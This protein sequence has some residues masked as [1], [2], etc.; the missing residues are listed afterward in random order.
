MSA[1]GSWMQLQA[2]WGS[3]C[4]GEFVEYEDYGGDVGYYCDE[5]VDAWAECQACDDT[6]CA[7]LR[8]ACNECWEG[9]SA[10]CEDE[11][12]G[13]DR[14]ACLSYEGCNDR[15][16]RDAHYGDEDAQ[17]AACTS[18][19][20]FCARCYSWGCHSEG[21][22][23]VCRMRSPN[24]WESLSRE[25]CE[26]LG[27]VYD[28]DSYWDACSR[29]VASTGDLET[30]AAA[31]FAA[32]GGGGLEVGPNPDK[33]EW[34]SIAPEYP[35]HG[36]WLEAGCYFGALDTTAVE[37]VVSAYD[38]CAQGDC[39]ELENLDA[40][41]CHNEAV[42]TD[43]AG[44][45]WLEWGSDRH[46]SEDA[47]AGN[48][49]C[50]YAY[51]APN[52]EGASAAACAA[53]G[54]GAWIGATLNFEPGRFATED[55]CAEGRCEG[56][57][58]W[59][60]YTREQ[61]LAEGRY[62]CDMQ[63]LQCVADAW[64]YHNQGGGGCF[65]NATLAAAH[66]GSEPCANELLVTEATCAATA[67]HEWASCAGA[68]A[69]ACAGGARADALGCAWRHDSC[70]DET[71]CEV[72]GWCDDYENERETCGDAGW[73]HGD[74]CWASYETT[75]TDD[76]GN[77]LSWWAYESCGDC[78][79]SSGVCVEPRDGWGCDDNRWHR[80]GCRA[81][82]IATAGECEAVDG[83][84]WLSRAS[85]RASCEATTSCYETM[86]GTTMK[87]DADC[88]AC[89]GDVV[90]AFRWHGGTWSEPT[91]QDLAWFANGQEMVPL[92]TVEKEV[93]DHRVED[94][95]AKPVMKAFAKT[96][97]TRSLLEYNSFS[98]S[99]L[100]LL[101]NCGYDA[102]TSP[103]GGFSG[104]VSASTTTFCGLAD[105]VDAGHAVVAVENECSGRR[106]LE[107]GAADDSVDL[108]LST[109]AV[110]TLAAAR[111][112]AVA[113][114][115]HTACANA[116]AIDALVV[117]GAGGAVV[118]Q[119]LGDG[120]GVATSGEVDALQLCLGTR[121]DVTVYGDYFGT[122]DL[123]RVGDDGATLEA[124]GF[125]LAAS[126]RLCASVDRAGTYFPILRVADVD[127][128]GDVDGNC[129]G[130]GD[131]G[132]CGGRG[133]CVG[134]D[135][136]HCFCGFTG[137]FC[138]SGC[139]NA[140]SGYGTCDDATGA[141]ACAEGRAG[142]ECAAV[143]CPRGDVAGESRYCSLRGTC[144]ESRICEC[145]AG[146]EG[147][148]CET[149]VVSETA[150]GGSGVDA[151]FLES[152]RIDGDPFAYLGVEP[153]P[154]T[155]PSRAPVAREVRI[156]SAVAFSEDL[157]PEA[158][159]GDAE[160]V[161]SFKVILV[162]VGIADAVDRVSDV[163][164]R[165]ARRRRLE[166]AAATVVDFALTV[167]VEVAA[168]ASDADLAAVAGETT[169]AFRETM[170][171]AATSGALADAVETGAS[172]ALAGVAVDEEATLAAVEET[173][174]SVAAADDDD[175]D[176]QAAGDDDD[177]SDGGDATLLVGA[178]AVVIA[179]AV[180]LALAC[181]CRRRSPKPATATAAKPTSKVAPGPP[182]L[183]FKG[184]P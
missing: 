179:S 165:S 117:E 92:N 90:S 94:E 41:A 7:P 35:W 135:F 177:S 16:V 91:V 69:D 66:C 28:E 136:C 9:S 50:Y 171:G 36:S 47:N 103:S 71:S 118:G 159:N 111:R 42:A 18:S 101:S 33:S 102:S 61:C 55:Q 106:R 40:V 53:A 181:A 128:V 178:A 2:G 51:D 121:A 146:Y 78:H 44:K 184:Q 62:S 63:C 57:N 116:G 175:A 182:D 160:A 174:A 43:D 132:A 100:G 153:A 137:D 170:D 158:F 134:G 142:D 6:N 37:A 1:G 120:V 3:C 65:R 20:P 15:S 98:E 154:T 82:G 99:L 125:D 87:S 152:E 131:G 130:G 27:G 14:D 129:G 54:G 67:G 34:Y 83:G 109:V 124:L 105:P 38:H 95:M 140:C 127:A 29:P 110:G 8:D 144:L 84:R 39:W 74:A 85:D 143:D 161:A 23:A 88:A 52:G 115:P 86:V 122:Y 30:D 48:G 157:D 93:T 163:R 12:V 168:G 79:R 104:S 22:A 19:E 166:D 141:C 73:T 58:E 138:E 80:L 96:A 151:G 10:C 56:L 114:E 119:V 31:C 59:G 133:A 149:I 183:G 97:R 32:F 169:A 147:D 68:D 72:E 49:A 77:E 148:A 145:D 167:V 4:F 126:T 172:G 24:Y 64:P 5:H 25:D 75:A 26:A 108:V 150:R 13:I 155:A 162:D 112:L 60:G 173:T 176:G 139:A 11:H 46:Y 113:G 45:S 89:G 123:A 156:E 180:A 164:A 81:D 70:P 17:A 107:A 21:V 76:Q